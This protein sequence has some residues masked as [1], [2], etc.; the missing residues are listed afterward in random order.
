MFSTESGVGEL[1]YSSF[2]EIHFT[3][4][5]CDRTERNFIFYGANQLKLAVDLFYWVENGIRFGRVLFFYCHYFVPFEEK[6]TNN[7]H[8]MAIFMIISVR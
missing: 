6:F 8:A 5:L 4:H 7:K 3:A 2:I 1:K